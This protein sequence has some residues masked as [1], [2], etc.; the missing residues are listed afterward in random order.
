MGQIFGKFLIFQCFF[1]N[2]HGLLCGASKD[3]CTLQQTITNPNNSK[4]NQIK[5]KR[6]IEQSKQSKTARKCMILEN[7]SMG[8]LFGIFVIFI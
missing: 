1:L 5:S 4:T 7:C 3:T 2:F 8:Q 6:N